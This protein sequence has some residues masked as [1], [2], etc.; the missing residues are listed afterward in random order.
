[1]HMHRVFGDVPAVVVGGAVDA[2]GFDAAACEP[3]GKGAAEVVATGVGAAGAALA[4]GGAAE[5]SGEYD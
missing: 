5:F 2:A 3:P 1:M 4:E